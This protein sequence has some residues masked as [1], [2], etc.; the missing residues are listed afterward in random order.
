MH[1]DDN[2]VKPQMS[3]NRILKA[4]GTTD[5]LIYFN[6]LFSLF[7]F[8]FFIEHFLEKFINVLP[9]LSD[10]LLMYVIVNTTELIFTAESSV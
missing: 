4:K 7:F 5:V 6:Y 9:F 8:F 1:R 10:D 2:A 3:A